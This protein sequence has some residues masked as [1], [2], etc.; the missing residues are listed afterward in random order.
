[1][2]VSYQSVPMDNEKPEAVSPH[3]H[4]ILGEDQLTDEAGTRVGHHLFI[5]EAGQAEE[6]RKTSGDSVWRV[7]NERQINV[8]DCFFWVNTTTSPEHPQPQH[9]NI[10]ITKHALANSTIGNG[11][12]LGSGRSLSSA[13]PGGAVLGYVLMGTV[14]SSVVSCLGEMTALM[15]VNAPIMEFPR[16][17]LDRGVGFAVGWIYW[18][19]YAVLAADQLVAVANTIRF[20]YIDDNGTHLEWVTGGSV[21][22]AVW[23]SVVLITVTLI[24]TLPVKYYGQLEYVFGCIKLSF[25]VLVILMMVILDTM[26]PLDAR[27]HKTP[28]S[29]R[30]WDSPYSFFAPKYTVRGHMTGEVQREIGGSVGTFLGVWTTFTNI[31][32]SY[33]GMDM[34]AA[35]AAESKALS[36]A[37]SMKMA[38]RKV[39]IR[40][41]TLYTLCVLTASFLVPY[42][43]PF[44]NGGGQSES[45]HSIF[46]IAVVQGG[47]PAAAHFFNAIYLF[48]A[49]ASGINTMY[50]SSRVLHTLALRDQTG[51]EFITRRLRQCHNGVP[52]RAVLVTGALM[53][54]GYLGTGS[55]DQRLSEL[56]TNCTVSCLI[57][58]IVV[59]ATY[60]GFFKTLHDVKL[61][62][63]TS[64]AQA[65]CYDRNHPQYP[66]KSHGQ[67][68]KACYG[69]VACTVL[70][71]FNGVPSF[72]QDPFDIRGFFASYI[73]VPVFFLL[74]IGYKLSKHGL[75]FS[76]WGPERSNDLRNCVQV[77]SEKRKGRLHFP[78][79]GLTKDNLQEFIQWI[80]VWTK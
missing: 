10:L 70:V 36:N 18:F 25:L 71:I 2:T 22:A 32:F 4:E 37:E 63:N 35:T 8:N 78:D 11:L 76:Q 5:D 50:V 80:W 42:D 65:A 24:N 30:Y 47:L 1:M 64:E 49:F 19:A 75:N 9:R 53:C 6:E 79:E 33:V 73:G 77:T 68:L 23:V 57:V 34:V 56:A 7:L 31:I 45:S 59:C 15:P 27:Y 54:L 29:T 20:K 61:Y 69:L 17:F 38:S 43:H 46:L 66:Y 16:R 72:L 26:Q 52:L 3:F 55:S 13:G 44:L 74:V 60:L 51:P 67:W 39:S 58:Y 62:G 28:V 21:H 40:V 14:I 48:S 12:F 41:V